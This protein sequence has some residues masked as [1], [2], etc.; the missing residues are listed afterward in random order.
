MYIPLAQSEGLRDPGQTRITI[1]VRPTAGSPLGLAASVAAGI[2]SIDP[3]VSFSFRPLDDVVSAAF[4]QER[5]VAVLSG[6]FGALAL[7]LAGIGLY[8]VSSYAASQR[9]IEIAVRMAL[10]AAPRSI[11]GLILRRVGILIGLGVIEGI[12]LSLWVS[13]LLSSFLYGL[14]PNDPAT[15]VGAILTLAAVGLAAGWLPA[16]RAVRIEPVEVLRE[17]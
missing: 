14:T 2:T 15:L 4:A 16:W 5:L 9:R 10:G 13:Q 8:G 1:G 7:V 12:V 17:N 3:N 6:I 11:V